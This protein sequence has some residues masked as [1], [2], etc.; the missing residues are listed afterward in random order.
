M[1][2]YEC[3]SSLGAAQLRIHCLA[4]NSRDQQYGVNS[5]LLVLSLNWFALSVILVDELA[6]YWN[7]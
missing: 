7:E 2:E 3:N 1:H 4:T 5:G 6:D